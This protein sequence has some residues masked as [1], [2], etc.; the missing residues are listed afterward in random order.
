ML[1]L[2]DGKLV[3]HSSIRAAAMTAVETPLRLQLATPLPGLDEL[4]ATAIGVTQV[5][6][7]GV[8]ATFNFSGD[9]AARY[10]LL[11]HL[12]EAGAEV[13]AF[14]EERL[15]MQQ[16]YLDSVRGVAGEVKA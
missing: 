7:A 6:V 2:R 12:I 16:A 14:A 8:T 5:T 1:V 9:D 11:R 3:A 15:N 10:R 13:C 4:L